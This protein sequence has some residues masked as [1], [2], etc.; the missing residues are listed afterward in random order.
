MRVEVCPFLNLLE[1]PVLILFVHK[2]I[3]EGFV[4]TPQR[5]SRQKVQT[6]AQ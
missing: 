4:E 1:G 5:R 2:E 3:E 6:E